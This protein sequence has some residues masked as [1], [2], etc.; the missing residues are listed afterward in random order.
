MAL[1]VVGVV[2]LRPPDKIVGAWV[3]L[4]AV[5]MPHLMEWRRPWWQMLA[6]D[7]D[8]NGEVLALAID[9]DADGRIAVAVGMLGEITIAEASPVG[10]GDHAAVTGDLVAAH[11]AHSVIVDAMSS[12]A[13]LATALVHENA[14]LAVSLLVL[15]GVAASIRSRAS[16]RAAFEATTSGCRCA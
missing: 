5:Q 15:Y 6:G 11:F 2:L 1:P 8:V 7:E 10:E 13:F 9:H 12:K 16:T 4:V 14:C 3:L